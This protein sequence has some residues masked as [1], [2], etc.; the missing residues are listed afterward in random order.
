M[1]KTNNAVKVCSLVAPMANRPAMAI[2]NVAAEPEIDA[3]NPAII[4]AF[5]SGFLVA[6]GLIY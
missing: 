2:P 5:S 6:A 4:G 3:T 1:S